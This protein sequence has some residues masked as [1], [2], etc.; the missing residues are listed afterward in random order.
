M[1]ADQ[2]LVEL[3][4]KYDVVDV[5]FLVDGAVPLQR[6]GRKHRFD[7]RYERDGNW[8]CIERV[9]HEVK[10]RTVRFSNYFSNAEAETADEWLRSFAFAWNQLI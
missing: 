7:F 8:N 2:F 10:R 4:E 5:T 9:F 6:A 1:I 3:R